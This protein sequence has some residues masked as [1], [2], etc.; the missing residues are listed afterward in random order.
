MTHAIELSIRTSTQ[1]RLTSELR[2]AISLLEMSSLDL[3][4]FLVEAAQE[5]P[6]IVVEP[7]Q[8]FSSGSY[9]KSA[10]NSDTPLEIAQETS[11]REFL[12]QQV[13]LT[14]KSPKDQA[15]GY[16]LIDALTEDG[17]YRE[18]PTLLAEQLQV[19]LKR[20]ETVLKQMKQFEPI[21]IFSGSLCS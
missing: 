12:T 10:W 19:S 5:N 18:D 17:F 21:G 1:L 7:P 11:L 20:V 8:I 9:K 13:H 4:S 6:F 14:F 15:I 16:Q 2:Q 3:T